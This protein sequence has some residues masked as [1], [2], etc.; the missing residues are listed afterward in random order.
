MTINFKGY[1]RS[2]TAPAVSI[3]CIA[4]KLCFSEIELAQ[5]PVPTYAEGH[6]KNEESESDRQDPNIFSATSSD[7]LGMKL[8]SGDI[9]FT[10]DLLT[11]Q[12]LVETVAGHFAET[13]LCR[14]DILSTDSL[15]NGHFVDK[16]FCRNDNLPKIDVCLFIDSR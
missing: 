2:N 13:T 11:E 3:A 10:D 4:T 15:P 6:S 5:L 9:V 1:V 8:D 7:E 12:Q 14:T 16:T